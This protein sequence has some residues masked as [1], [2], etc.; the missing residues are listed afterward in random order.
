M[1]RVHVDLGGVGRHQLSRERPLLPRKPAEQ[2]GDDY[3]NHADPPEHVAWL[4]ASKMAVFAVHTPNSSLA[5]EIQA[6]NRPP[7]S[8]HALMPPE[9]VLTAAWVPLEQLCDRTFVQTCVHNRVDCALTRL[10]IA[11]L[12][13]K[14]AAAAATA[15]GE[16]HAENEVAM[17][18]PEQS[19]PASTLASTRA[20]CKKLHERTAG[21]HVCARKSTHASKQMRTH[22]RTPTRTNA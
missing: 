19:G 17:P 3:E 1:L 11:L 13:E 5:E 6:L 22:V 15:V 16:L 10:G 18:L 8:D 9:G 2:V 7:E 14:E 12:D 4:A 21:T 20:A